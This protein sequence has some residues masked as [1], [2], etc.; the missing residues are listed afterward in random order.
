M[1]SIQKKDGLGRI[2]SIHTSHGKILTPVLLP[3][4]NPNRQEIPPKEM[5]ECGAEAF[6]TNAYLLYK[7]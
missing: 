6:I 1:F 4:I 7:D 2:G 5:V 3:V